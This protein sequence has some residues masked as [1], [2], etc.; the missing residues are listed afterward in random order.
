MSI[1]STSALLSFIHS[2]AA[3]AAHAPTALPPSTMTM[4]LNSHRSSFGFA[5]VTLASLFLLVLAAMP[6]RPVQAAENGGVPCAACTSVMTL[7]LELSVIHDKGVD[8]ALEYLCLLLPAP[9]E[10]PYVAL[11]CS[12]WRTRMSLCRQHLAHGRRP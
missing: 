4:P 6:V 8:Q 11:A 5:A 12:L 3:A 1:S 9:F 2:P 7:V 10:N